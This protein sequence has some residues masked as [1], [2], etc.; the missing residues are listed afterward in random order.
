[1]TRKEAII[2]NRMHETLRLIWKEYKTPDQIRQKSNSVIDAAETLAM[3]YENI[4]E[5][6][7]RAIKYVK[8]ADENAIVI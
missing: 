3:S 5:M 7:R 1:M 2:F 6:A 4:Q 8:K